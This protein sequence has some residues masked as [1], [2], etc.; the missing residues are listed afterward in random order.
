MTEPYP[1]EAITL[2]IAAAAIVQYAEATP[3]QR[4]EILAAS[5]S[6]IDN[7]ATLATLVKEDK[8]Q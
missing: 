1:A 8:A 3:K 6:I 7:L 5:R 4:K 2:G